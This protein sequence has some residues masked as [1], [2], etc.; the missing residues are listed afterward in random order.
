MTWVQVPH[1][2]LTLACFKPGTEDGAALCDYAIIWHSFQKMKAHSSKRAEICFCSIGGDLALELAAVLLIPE[3]CAEAVGSPTQ[4]S[5][6]ALPAFSHFRNSMTSRSSALDNNRARFFN[7]DFVFVALRNSAEIF[8]FC[9]RNN[10]CPA[11][12]R[13]EPTATSEENCFPMVATLAP[14]LGLLYPR[15]TWPPASD[16]T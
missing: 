10:T 6:D 12:R 2:K 7:L 4:T 14:P 15:L 8:L 3:G 9:A 1:Q 11:R 5:A 13:S 16:R